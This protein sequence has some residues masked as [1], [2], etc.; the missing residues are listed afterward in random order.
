VC[1]CLDLDS[2]G[3][4]SAGTFWPASLLQ[5]LTAEPLAPYEGVCGYRQRGLATQTPPM[6][7]QVANA[8][9]IGSSALRYSDHQDMSLSTSLHFNERWAS[10]IMW[11]N[12]PAG[13]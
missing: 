11:S 2:P 10:L 3:C 8:E 1:V 12:P 6:F 5:P 9:G 4:C 7:L 13:R